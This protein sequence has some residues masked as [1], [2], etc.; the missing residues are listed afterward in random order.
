M[1]ALS[2]PGWLFLNLTLR[3]GSM[4]WH[5]ASTSAK[6]CCSEGGLQRKD[7]KERK[8]K[9]KCKLFI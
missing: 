5:K 9:N 7:E 2:N 4:S 3:C 1:F 6:V 8:G